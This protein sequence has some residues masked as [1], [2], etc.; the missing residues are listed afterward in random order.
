MKIDQCRTK[1]K[2]SRIKVEEKGRKAVFLN[3]ARAE[4]YVTRIDGC[5]VANERAADYMVTKCEVGDIVI[6]LKGTDTVHAVSQIAAAVPVVRRHGHCRG[7]FVGLVV[8]RRYPKVD[9]SLQRVRGTFR[10][11]FRTH[12]HIVSRNREFDFEE[13]LAADELD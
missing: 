9:T 6:E 12:V 13:T 1:L 2:H 7:R 3:P 4:Y 11:N 5:L 8:C 10:K